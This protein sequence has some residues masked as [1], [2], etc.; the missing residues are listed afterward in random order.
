MRRAAGLG[1]TLLLLA[2]CA[3]DRAPAPILRGLQSNIEYGQADG[4]SL[5]LDAFVPAGNGP[6]A[7]V[8]VVHG[9]GWGGG[10][11]A[12]DI[13]G[14]LR[15]LGDA[16][17]AWFSINYRLAPK[18]QWPDCY[19]DL[20]TAVRWV[21][22]HAADY[23]VDPN[24]IALIGYSAGGEMVCLDAVQA[25]G[26]DQVAAVV[27]V[28]PPTDMEADTQ[29]RGGLSKSLIAL[30]GTNKLDAHSYELLHEMSAIHYVHAGLPPF[31]LIHG[32]AD[33]SVPYSQSIHF[34]ARLE[35]LGVP[36]ELVTLQNAPHDINKWDAID[37]SYKQKMIE[38]L[39]RK[40][41]P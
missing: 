37:A 6:F 30:F 2:G 35:Q 31:L 29:R 8:I 21:K 15:A 26:A 12:K 10:D 40:L 3:Q 7:A 5:L 41:A 34:Q 9:G 25:Q 16:N 1:L 14:L 18:Y 11:K 39:R 36:C 33:K 20:K 32:T 19:D 13:T 28:S 17:F 22:A 27:G 38:W 4:Q 24:R 23:D